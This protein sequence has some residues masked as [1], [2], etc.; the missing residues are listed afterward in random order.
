[1]NKPKI[2]H[3][4]SWLPKPDN[5]YLGN[6]CFRHLEAVAPFSESVLLRVE[7]S[8]RNIPFDIAVGEN[9]SYRSVT[10]HIPH[11]DS[12]LISKWLFFRG[13]NKGYSYICKHIFKP[14]LLHLHV[15]R[16]LGV[17]ALFWKK[18]HHLPFVW[19]EHS[20]MYLQPYMN[21]LGFLWKLSANEASC[22]MPVSRLLA[23]KLQKLGVNTPMEIIYN[24]L[25]KD[26]LSVEPNL[27]YGSPWHFL[28]ISTLNSCKNFMGILHV[29][30]R[31]KTECGFQFELDVVHDFP[32]DNYRQW[33]TDHNLENNIRFLGA[34]GKEELLKLYGSSHA[35]VMFS[36]IE[37][38]SCTVMEAVGTGIAVFA[39]ATGA[40]PEML[41]DGRGVLIPIGDEEALF[42]ALLGMMQ[43]GYKSKTEEQKIYARE[44][45]L[46]ENIGKQ[47]NS[48]YRKVLDRNVS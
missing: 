34:K 39:T 5:P 45:F 29:M 24:V 9:C 31:L 43:N 18:I 28:H 2:L 40:I 20:T 30:E 47:I 13:Y 10:V 8:N 42:Q 14:E 19:S 37:T 12:K 1:M 48:V 36:N 38:F 44:N 17:M 41:A 16:N 35:L 27:N 21:K 32:A 3:I 11:S 15:A 7:M 46:A 22:V 26:Y 25:D 6:F 4:M 33:V 23:D